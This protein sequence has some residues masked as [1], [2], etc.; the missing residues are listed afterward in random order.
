MQVM[1]DSSEAKEEGILL[2]AFLRLSHQTQ[3]PVTGKWLHLARQA[4]TSKI[5]DTSSVEEYIEA[6]LLSS[7]YWQTQNGNCIG[8]ILAARILQALCNKASLTSTISCNALSSRC[9]KGIGDKER[10][11]VFDWLESEFSNEY[12]ADGNWALAQLQTMYLFCLG[13]QSCE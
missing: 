6:L 2:L 12:T 3:T 5:L 10:R 4:H 13:K 7:R 11:L 8:M 1:E 9:L